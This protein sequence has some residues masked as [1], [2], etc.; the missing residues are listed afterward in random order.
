MLQDASGAHGGHVADVNLRRWM[1]VGRYGA[2][3]LGLAASWASA[4]YMDTYFSVGAAP[5]RP[6][7]DAGA[8][9]R[10]A[11]ITAVYV[12]PLSGRWAVGA[13]VMYMH[14]LEEAADSPA[15]RSDGQVYAGIGVARGW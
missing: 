13:G 5:D 14:F 9:W 4:D 12:Q 10:D 8:G 7:Y 11:R 1:P 3:G 15:V 2:L 6:G